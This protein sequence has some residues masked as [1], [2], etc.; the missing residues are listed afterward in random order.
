ML[1]FLFIYQE[2][3][4][5]MLQASEKTSSLL[6]QT[7]HKEEQEQ[8]RRPTNTQNLALALLLAT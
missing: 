5:G 2:T 4:W 8:S 7:E 1:S 6:I 3:G